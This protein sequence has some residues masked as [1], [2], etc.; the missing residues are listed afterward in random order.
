MN[1]RAYSAKIH[2]LSLSLS[3]LFVSFLLLFRLSPPQIFTSPP[4]S[5][6]SKQEEE[7]EEEEEEDFFFPLSFSFYA[8]PPFSPSLPLCGEKNFFV[9]APG[10]VLPL[11]HFRHARFV[12]PASKQRDFLG[13]PFF[14]FP[15]KERERER[16]G[17]REG[18]DS[19]KPRPVH[20]E[21]HETTPFRR[22]RTEPSSSSSRLPSF[23]PSLPP[24]PSISAIRSP[25]LPNRG[26]SRGCDQAS[27]WR[28]PF[29]N[30]FLF[31]L[32]SG[33]QLRYDATCPLAG[34]FFDSSQ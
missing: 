17:E 28:R 7:E 25:F 16:D 32:Q 1:V 2:S 8:L 6:R 14:L 23:S 31:F 15:S 27:R 21:D 22:N 12:D 11:L 33:R 13:P 26:Q 19:T 24:H 3:L 30:L 10:F 34:N 4:P 18:I 20:G 9:S 5:L 29:P